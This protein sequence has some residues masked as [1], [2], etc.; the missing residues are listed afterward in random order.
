M[1]HVQRVP[2]AEG[3]QPPRAPIQDGT[4]CRQPSPR[5]SMA[6]HG[7]GGIRATAP[8]SPGA[9]WAVRDAVAGLNR[10]LLPR[11]HRAT[12]A[13]EVTCIALEWATR[14]SQF[15]QALGRSIASQRELP[16]DA[17]VRDAVLDVFKLDFF[18]DYLREVIKETLDAEQEDV[19]EAFVTALV[20][21]AG[22]QLYD[23]ATGILSARI[24]AA[25]GVL[26]R[27]ATNKH[28]KSNLKVD[29]LALV[30]ES[31]RD[32]TPLSERIARLAKK[33]GLKLTDAK[34]RRIS[35][36][37]LERIAEPWRM[38][39]GVMQKVV[40]KLGGAAWAAATIFFTP[41]RISRS[42]DDVLGA[43]VDQIEAAIRA[44]RSRIGEPALVNP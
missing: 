30:M 28:L 20:T 18:A 27:K 44:A 31:T 5:P 35:M 16:G 6:G 26:S 8:G 15:E 11:L 40:R 19:T 32:R 17:A 21:E 3:R 24:L 33:H 4:L 34:I 37:I 23:I 1:T 2:G 42:S 29:W 9:Y 12:G 39:P 41:S 43:Q 22:Q 36:R 25:V 10:E 38:M 14:R 7:A 13:D